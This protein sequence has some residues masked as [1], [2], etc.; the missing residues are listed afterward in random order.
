MPLHTYIYIDSHLV[1]SA[2]ACSQVQGDSFWK[3]GQVPLLGVTQAKEQ[4]DWD[5]MRWKSALCSGSL[6]QR[7]VL[8]VG[9]WMRRESTGLS[10]REVLVKSSWGAA[11]MG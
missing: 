5:D 4:M 9:R 2:R 6:V 7:R 11:L 3:A 10:P 1:Q 8:K